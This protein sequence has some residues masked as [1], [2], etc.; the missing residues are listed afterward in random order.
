LIERLQPTLPILLANLVSVG[1]VALVY[2]NDIE[3][4]LAVFPMSINAEQARH[5]RQRKH[6]A[7][8]PG[9]VPE[10]QPQPQPAAAVRPRIHA[11]SAAADPHVRGLPE[12]A[13]PATCTAGLPQDSWLNVRGARNTPCETVPGKRAPTV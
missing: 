1:E 5:R 7:G 2:Q 10:L 11:G 3:Q 9:S 8:I 12:P 13:R 6:Q 4:L